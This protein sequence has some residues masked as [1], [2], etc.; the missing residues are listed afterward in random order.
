MCGIFR[1]KGHVSASCVSIYSEMIY[2]T[3]LTLRHPTLLLSL[4]VLDWMWAKL[5]INE[6]I[7]FMGILDGQAFSSLDYIKTDILIRVIYEF[8]ISLNSNKKIQYYTVINIYI[9]IMTVA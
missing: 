4:V 2:H 5:L 7:C 6:Q 3:L 9:N 1:L 8:P